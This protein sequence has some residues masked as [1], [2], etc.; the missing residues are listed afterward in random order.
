MVYLYPTISSPSF[1]SCLTCH[2]DSTIG[3]LNDVGKAYSVIHQWPPGEVSSGQNILVSI[4]GFIHLFASMILVGSMFFVHIIHKASTQAISVVPKNELKVGWISLF[5]IGISR[6][7][8][9]RIRLNSL[10]GLLNSYP[11]KLVL[12]KIIVYFSRNCFIALFSTVRNV[13]L[14]VAFDIFK[15]F[16]KSVKV[17]S[18]GYL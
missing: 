8:L 2:T 9:T 14:N 11:G 10:D 1:N 5:F 6:I 16:A 12:G 15:S 18:L 7:Y 17:I 3:E 4:V 13:W